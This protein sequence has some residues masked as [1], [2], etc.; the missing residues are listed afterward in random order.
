MMKPT[1]IVVSM[2]VL[3]VVAMPLLVT[4]SFPLR[5]A[6]AVGVSI[7]LGLGMWHSHLTGEMRTNWGTF[8]R[9]SRPVVFAVEQVFWAIVSVAFAA[10][11]FAH[12]FRLLW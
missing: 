9:D 2:I 3:F 6:G 5:L 10:G 12:A 11:T 1:A 4:Q 8:R 7:L